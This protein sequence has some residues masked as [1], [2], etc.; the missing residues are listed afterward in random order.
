MPS[1]SLLVPE[2]TEIIV[3]LV[4]VNVPLFAIKEAGTGITEGVDLFCDWAVK[5]PKAN[6]NGSNVFFIC[7]LL[8]L[9]TCNSPK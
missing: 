3:L 5:I 6:I 4:N 1:I 9:V 2:E 8:I 7:Q